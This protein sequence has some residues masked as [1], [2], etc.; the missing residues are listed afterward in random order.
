[1][2]AGNVSTM[3]RSKIKIACVYFDKVGRPI[4]EVIFMNCIHCGKTVDYDYRVKHLGDMF[5]YEEHLLQ[6][7]RSDEDQRHPLCDCGCGVYICESL[8]NPDF[9]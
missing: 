6:I 2:L 5:C 3:F 8:L 7:E 9:S 1:M 4:R